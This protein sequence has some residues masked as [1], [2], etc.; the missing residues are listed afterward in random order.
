[1][2]E[3]EEVEDRPQKK[4]GK[5]K[6]QKKKKGKSHALLFGILGAVAFLFL[7]SGGVGG[8]VWWKYFSGGSGDDLKYLPDNSQ[9]VAS[10]RVNEL[11]TSEVFKELKR[12]VPQIDQQTG[13]NMSKEIG[14]GPEDIESVTIGGGGNFKDGIVVLRT[15]KAIDGRDLVG[16]IKNARYTETKVGKY[17]V[18]ESQDF[19]APAF[20]LVSKTLIIVGEKEPVRAVLMRDKKPTFSTNLQAAMT[21]V[22]F[23]KTIAFAVDIKASTS[24]PAGGG[25]LP[26]LG[27]KASMSAGMDKAQALVFQ[28][29]IA[30]DMRLDLVLLCQDAKSAEDVKK[31]V[32]GFLVMG[33]NNQ[34]IP[35][36]FSDLLDIPIKTNGSTVTASKTIRVSPLIQAYK[37]KGNQR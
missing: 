17:V 3:V 20:C 9:F 23:S 21:K 25:G 32:D 2:D 12:E 35:K 16:K 5:K 8:L 24:Q 7:C 28:A 18:Q 14:L 34:M 22:D 4:R 33:R 15:K 36:E 19:G 29:K 10:I 27:D 13:A 37:Q 26:F 1:V 30:A 11:M 6:S 31:V